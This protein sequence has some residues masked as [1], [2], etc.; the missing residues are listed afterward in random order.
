MI[1]EYS[2][3]TLVL[4][5]LGQ[6]EIEESKI[7]TS[8]SLRGLVRAGGRGSSWYEYGYSNGCDG[9]YTDGV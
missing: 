1:Y 4:L 2:Y 3:S 5:V 9:L 7:V 8:T 6:I